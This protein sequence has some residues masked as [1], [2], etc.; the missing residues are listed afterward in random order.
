ME[1]RRMTSNI[2]TLVRRGPNGTTRLLV[3][4]GTAVA[5][6]TLLIKVSNM[7]TDLHT[8]VSGEIEL[9]QTH[10]SAKAGYPK[11]LERVRTLES[12][13]E[14]DEN[15]DAFIMVELAAIRGTLDAVLLKLSK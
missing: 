12:A 8:F 10:C 9:S 1:I 6:V 7:T 2:K 4:F 13:C 15:T 14:A 5:L 3:Y 11:V